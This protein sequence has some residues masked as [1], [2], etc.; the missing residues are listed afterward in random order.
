MRI[1][2]RLFN[3]ISIYKYVSWNIWKHLDGAW[4]I[5]TGWQ[6]FERYLS[7]YRSPETMAQ[8]REPERCTMISEAVIRNHP[9]YFWSN[10]I[11]SRIVLRS[12]QTTFPKLI[13]S[14][15]IEIFERRSCLFID[16]KSI[17]SF[18][19]IWMSQALRFVYWT[20]SYHS[21]RTDS[22]WRSKIV[23]KMVKFKCF[24]WLV[25]NCSILYAITIKHRQ[26]YGSK[27]EMS[28]CDAF[29]IFKSMVLMRHIS[30]GIA[31]NTSN[32]NIHIDTIYNF[33][34][35]S[36]PQD[37]NA[38]NSF[39]TMFDSYL[40]KLSLKFGP[41]RNGDFYYHSSEIDV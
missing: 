21:H 17:K 20:V 33:S 34:F 29:N 10:S 23:S 27:S 41:K 14:F 24:K 40:L 32:E 11:S 22:V 13:A 31:W 8:M 35:D 15:L 5:L 36:I 18:E 30:H 3:S 19:F 28:K 25:T 12:F 39:D 6:F 4:E 2:N 1:N 9:H 7:Q 26:F 37:H 38:Y 16:V